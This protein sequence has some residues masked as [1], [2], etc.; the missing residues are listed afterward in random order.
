MGKLEG[1]IISELHAVPSRVSLEI[2]MDLLMVVGEFSTANLVLG[3]GKVWLL[4][5]FKM[6]EAS[7]NVTLK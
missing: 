3:E 4:N 7:V 1:T 2:A 6:F 5:D